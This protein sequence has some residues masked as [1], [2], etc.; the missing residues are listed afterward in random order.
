M[1]ALLA[2]AMACGDPGAVEPPRAGGDTTI[3]D[4]TS[5]AFG[6]PAPNLGEADLASHL[7]GDVRF[8]ATF[9]A[10]PAD[11]N[12]GLGPLYN[13]TACARCHLR[14]GRG[15]PVAGPG[16]LGSHL[17]VRVSLV[18]ADPV[19]GA[20]PT[21]PELGSQ[22][23]DHATYGTPP[24]ASVRLT[25]T[26]QRGWYGDGAPFTLRRPVVEVTLPGGPLPAA[27]L[28]SPRIPPPVFGLGLLEAIAA[29]DLAARADPDDDDGDGISGRLNLVTDG[30]G[31]VVP[32]R[33]GW[34]A[35]APDLTTLAAQSYAAELGVSSPG[36]PDPDGAHD[37][38]AVVI[39]ETA[40]YTR[41]LAVP[42]RAV[43]D[44]PE[45]ARGESL[46]SE[47]G[48]AACHVES[49]RTG[50]H[51]IQALRDQL[52]HPYTDLLLHNVGFDLADGR[53]EF[54]A[55]G[56]EW[57]TPPLW[58]LGLSQTVLPNAGLLHDG[59]AR[60]IAE[61]ILWHG[62]EAERAKEGFRVLAPSDRRAVLTFLGAL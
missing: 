6:V 57:R 22:I 5:G 45:I 15:L 37:V 53:P 3:D 61:A 32:G 4:R 40:F 58:G 59:R 52:I 26:E 30:A 33:F 27:V 31:R 28:V 23:Q 48:C 35:T 25:W 55:S 2:L 1:V 47:L 13:H 11:V 34:K 49:W 60:T 46:F 8:E 43:S 50:D 19:T 51:E 16:P 7:R 14:D 24:E 39:D 21:V 54:V 44:D 10:S 62:G 56:T 9:V 18:G 12:P 20:P 42:A 17:V 38:D 29:A 36:F 41:T